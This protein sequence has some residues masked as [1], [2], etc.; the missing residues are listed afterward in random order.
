MKLEDWVL[1]TIPSLSIKYNFNEIIIQ[2][3]HSSA[4][5]DI[6]MSEYVGFCVPNVMY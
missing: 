3:K 5:R 2:M 6:I 4:L 1:Y